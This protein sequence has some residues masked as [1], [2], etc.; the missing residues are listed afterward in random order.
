[1]ASEP[2]KRYLLQQVWG[3]TRTFEDWRIPE[4]KSISEMYGVKDWES[5][6]DEK[7]YD[8]NSPF[9]VVRL[10]SDDLARKIGERLV[11]LKNI[12]EIWGEGKTFEEAANSAKAYIQKNKNCAAYMSKGKTFA[13][14][15]CGFGRTYSREEQREVLNPF[16][17]LGWKGKANLSCPDA[18]F[19]IFTDC[20]HIADTK[21]PPK[22]VWFCRQITDKTMRYKLHKYSLK[23][24]P[25]IGPTSTCSELAFLMANQ[26]QVKAGSVVFD[27]FV[28]TASLLVAASHFG[29]ICVGNDLDYCLLHSKIHKPK[30]KK[31]DLFLNFTHYG[32]ERPEIVCGDSANPPWRSFEMFDSIICDPPYGVRAGARKSGSRAALRGRK[33]NPVDVWKHG[34]K[35]IPSSIPYPVEELMEDLMDFAGKYLAIKGRIV[36]LLPTV[37]EFKINTIPQHPCL[38]F[39]AQSAQTLTGGFHRRCITFKKTKIHKPGLVCKRRDKATEPPPAFAD[40]KNQIFSGK[41]SSVED[42]GDTKA[43]D[44]KPS[45]VHVGEGKEQPASKKRKC[46]S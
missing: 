1:M 10:S 18:L 43:T 34:V 40:V 21:K 27:P 45:S 44:T 46:N 11:M 20:G 25:F 36:F 22:K 13:L 3:G 35:H 2:R 4:L 16:F 24:R 29:A 17:E 6:Y 23:T 37:G 31:K 39:V 41:S 32:F 33:I 12:H 26:A 7:S 8:Q 9:V 42:S 38:E 14:R 19:Y 5:F 30:A 15:V 28:G